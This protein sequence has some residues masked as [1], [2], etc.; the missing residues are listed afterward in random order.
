LD[1]EFQDTLDELAVAAEH[2]DVVVID[3]REGWIAMDANGDDVAD[4]QVVDI[5]SD[6][7]MDAIHIDDDSTASQISPS[8]G[9]DHRP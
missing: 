1:I 6:G 8:P 2:G 5:D 4:I 9:N 3:D 7:E